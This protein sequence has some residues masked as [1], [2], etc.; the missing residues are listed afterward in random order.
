ME[1]FYTPTI[2]IVEDSESMTKLFYKLASSSGLAVAGMAETGSEAVHKYEM[3]NPDIVLMDIMIPG[4]DGV[5]AM[6]RILKNDSEAEVVLI[7]GFSDLTEV[8]ALEAGAAALFRKPIDSI[9]KF[10]RTLKE[11][12]NRRAS[13]RTHS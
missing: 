13:K 7:S 12:G 2:L 9:S 8:A 6:K 5:E 3:L 11:C 4:F 1:S 10:C